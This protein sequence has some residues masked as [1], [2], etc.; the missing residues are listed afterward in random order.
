MCHVAMLALPPPRRA[1]LLAACPSGLVAAST[2]GRVVH[3]A[4][5]DDLARPLCAY[6]LPAR[7][8]LL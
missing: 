3:I 4:A 7:A 8:I 1:P 5:A 2:C 6:R